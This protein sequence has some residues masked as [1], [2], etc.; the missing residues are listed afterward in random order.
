M[1]HHLLL[2]NYTDFSGIFCYWGRFSVLAMPYFYDLLSS[3][4]L[5]EKFDILEDTQKIFLH[6]IPHV[7]K[8]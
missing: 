5:K 4:R 1:V 7:S 2:K 6:I 3:W 8:N